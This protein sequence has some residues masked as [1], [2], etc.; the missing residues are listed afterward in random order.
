MIRKIRDSL[1]IKICLL[2]MLLL[3]AASGI[4][5]FTIARFLPVYYSSQL[6]EGLDEIS[7]E[8]AETISTHKTIEEAASVIKLFEAS[9]QVA[10]VILD[11]QGELV[12][13]ILEIAEETA[14]V[15]EDVQWT[16][17]AEQAE[18][19]MRAVTGGQQSRRT[20]E[21]ENTIAFRAEAEETADS[22]EEGTA[23]DADIIEAI[24]TTADASAS[25][26]DEQIVEEITFGSASTASDIQEIFGTDNEASAVKHYDL[27][28]GGVSYTM[29]VSGGMQPVNQ[30]MEIL[31]EIFPYILGVSALAAVLLA[32]L[33]SCYLT[34]P[35]VRLSR[36]SRRMAALDFTDTCQERRTDEIGILGKNLDTMS[37][38][39]RN[40]LEN[41]QQANAKLKSDI[42]LEREIER[43]R[44]AFF[45][46]VSHE[47]KTPITILKGH[48]S[49]MQ[50]RVGAYCDR[51]YYLKRS[52][53]T[54][55]KMED[56]VGE[57]LT[58]SRLESR[59]FDTKQ[60]D[61]A[62]L[63]RLE[64]AQL[65]ELIEDKGLKL[66]VE[67]PEHL[68]AE[69][70]EGMM[71]KVFGNLLI[72][73]IRYTPEGKGNQIRVIMKRELSEET[74]S[75]STHLQKSEEADS[76]SSGNF[77][78]SLY[79]GAIYCSI[80]NTGVHIPEDA[81]AHIFEAF[82]R[83]EQ[84]RNRQMGGSGLGLYIVKM[85]LEQHGAQYAMEN[86]K[87]G[88]RAWFLLSMR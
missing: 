55:E 67:I 8:M 50:Q 87:E 44:I 42:E 35:V 56:M 73:A 18:E 63:L 12:W 81:L 33:A 2:V 31:K 5:Y 10:V 20:D 88:V 47:L 28:I 74:L 71:E 70:N 25:E 46:A 45:S 19:S 21:T 80:E 77:E 53:E 66:L 85:V 82:Y 3:I 62:E 52:L 29:L 38:N 49:G 15:T 40:T 7:R 69:V 86:T 14:V 9:S 13:P 51:D 39:L 32:L 61:I 84:S 4:T 48:L 60:T 1:T 78:N 79:K 11:E 76:M 27:K 72:N 83:V 64:L 65:A 54:A 30:A 68:D 16:E 34:R 22:V 59:G 24:G 26:T 36:I 17:G 41:L 6:E 58:V 43:K 37:S 23:S 57:L 75:S